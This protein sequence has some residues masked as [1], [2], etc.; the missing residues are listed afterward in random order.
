MKKDQQERLNVF[1]KIGRSYTFHVILIIGV[2]VLLNLVSFQHQILKDQSVNATYTLHS[3]TTSYLKSNAITERETTIKI[4][5]L[6]TSK[7]SLLFKRLQTTFELMKQQNAQQFEFSL[8]DTTRQPEEAAIIASNYDLTLSRETLIIDAR[9]PNN[10]EK[11]HIRIIDAEEMLVWGKDSKKRSFIKA[12]QD[13]NIILSNLIKAI[14]GNFRQAYYLTDGFIFPDLQEENVLSTLIP[15]LNQQNINLSPLSLNLTPKI[16]EDTKALFL[17]GPKNLSEPHIKAIQEYAAKKD[18]AIWISF[19]GNEQPQLLRNFLR[20]YGVHLFRDIVVSKSGNNI[21][22]SSNVLMQSQTGLLKGLEGNYT[23]L[24]GQTSSLT[25]D[26][27]SQEWQARQ[28][29]KEP[30][31]ISDKNSWGESSPTTTP[32]RYNQ[33]IDA[34][35]PLVLGAA[36]QQGEEDLF[37]QNKRMVVLGNNDFL[38]RKNITKEQLDF[39]NNLVNWLVARESLIGI[40]PK[41]LAF[42]RLTIS[43]DQKKLLQNIILVGIPCFSLLIAM[44]T[45]IRRKR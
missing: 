13:E 36:I 18:S 33:G 2:L 17:L 27:T 7:N 1:Q 28:I 26:T 38:L 31:L 23:T 5:G 22:T 8:I 40:H 24:R 32:I 4:Y 11:T 6:L 21:Q 16:P 9:S 19:N 35:G 45:W 14:E 42:Y 41:D 39:T 44:F 43:T 20:D 34:P 25:L 29:H 37:K 10:S 30:I 12:I 3:A 15:L